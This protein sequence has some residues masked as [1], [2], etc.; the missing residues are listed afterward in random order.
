LRSGALAQVEL[1]AF[2]GVLV[3]ARV[4]FVGFEL[5]PHTRS[6]AV[7]LEAANTPLAAWSERFPIRPGMSGRARIETGREQA[8]LSVPL[9]A[10]WRRGELDQVFVRTADGAFELRTVQ[11]GA[12]SRERVAVLGGVSA[13]DEVAV[14]GLF[15]LKSMLARGDE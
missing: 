2:P 7:R 10:L 11:L 1:A 6:A 9:S 14:D 8:A 3:P 4:A 5:D 12:R 13:A 15:F